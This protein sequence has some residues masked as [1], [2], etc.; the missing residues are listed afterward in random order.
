MRLDEHDFVRVE[1]TYA[2]DD[3]SRKIHDRYTDAYLVC[4]PARKWV[5]MEYGGTI[6]NLNDK[7]T[8]TLKSVLEYGDAIDEMH[9]ATKFTQEFARSDIGYTSTSVISLEVI[10]RDLPEEELYLSH[11][12]LPEP[13]FERG[14]FGPWV[15]YLIGGIACIAIGVIV[16]KRRRAGGRTRFPIEGAP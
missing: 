6:L 4:D 1:F 12:G 15:W 2:V 7:A 8:G 16:V 11:Y 5:V 9:L 3:P 13:N 14:W 10:G